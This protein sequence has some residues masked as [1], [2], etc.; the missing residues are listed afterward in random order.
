M[1]PDPRT[2]PVTARVIFEGVMLMCINQLQQYEVGM[3]QCPLHEPKINIVES[4][5]GSNSK[6]HDIV[7]PAGHDLIFRVNNPET[8]G[9]TLFQNPC[10]VTDFSNVID[11]ESPDFHADGVTVETELL[12]GRRL[13]FT[14][15]TVYAHK[16]SDVEFDLFTWENEN[17]MGSPVG[18]YLG[19][20]ADQIGIKIVCR[21]EPVGGID[22]ID[23]T[24]GTV[25]ES[26]S[27][28][29]TSYVITIN[30]DCRR[31]DSGPEGPPE[32]IANPHH[33][34][35]QPS[36]EP[37]NG[38]DFRFYY[39]LLKSRDGRKF[40]LSIRVEDEEETG[41]APS[42]GA[43][44]ATFLGQTDGLGLYD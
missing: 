20:I 11:L 18:T 17:E 34:T 28:R 41:P 37:A 4:T 10:S 22:L 9:V 32:P 16:L 3:I 6:E 19:H 29:D 39:G 44:E 21:D 43:C 31:E 1:Y 24:T 33:E 14:A 23:Y 35:G 2:N 26:L 5:I 7:W 27:K 25:I 15:G 30:N 40:D 12:Q 36:P 13:A 8:E 42:P 38:T